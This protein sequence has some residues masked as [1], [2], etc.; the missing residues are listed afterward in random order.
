MDNSFSM[1]IDS[2]I[3]AKLNPKKLTISNQNV[4]WNWS[5]FTEFLFYHLVKAYLL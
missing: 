1:K 4:K 2:Q 5:H 3:P